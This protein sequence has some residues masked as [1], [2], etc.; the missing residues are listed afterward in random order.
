L[1]YIVLLTETA[2][3]IQCPLVQVDVSAGNSLSTPQ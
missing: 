3:T 1:Y 2:A